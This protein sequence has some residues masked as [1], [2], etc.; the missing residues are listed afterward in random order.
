M[1][2]IAI[3]IIAIILG[4]FASAWPNA[5]AADSETSSANVSRSDELQ[6]QIAAVEQQLASLKSRL[7]ESQGGTFVSSH[8]I[9][10][11]V[12]PIE[13][14]VVNVSSTIVHPGQPITITYLIN[15]YSTQYD[16]Y[17]VPRVEGPID[18]WETVWFMQ[19]ENRDISPGDP[20]L[21]PSGYNRTLQVT[22]YPTES[23][24]FDIN[25]YRTVSKIGKE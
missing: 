21:I 9:D 12:E 19:E 15:N 7:V 4:V 11:I 18:G 13:V 23:A 1:K 22:I 8:R 17:V 14:Q 6:A 25:F 5:V 20:I 3:I 10:V 2:K 16:W 24:S